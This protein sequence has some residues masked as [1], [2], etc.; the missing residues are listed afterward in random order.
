MS[1]IPRRLIVPKNITDAL[2][3]VDFPGSKENIVDLDMVQ[4]IRIAGK[5]VSFSL[6][7]QRS[8]DPQ[9]EVVKEACIA[10]IAKY[11]GD[12]VE[13]QGNISVKA[14]HQMERPLLAGVRNIVAVASGKGGVGKSTVSVNLAVALANTGAKVGLI[15]ADIFGPSL[16]KM[17]GVEDVRPAGIKI[18]GRDMIEP[19]EKFGVKMLSIGFFVAAENALIWRGPMASNALKQLIA[20][21]NWGDLDYLL[22]DLPPGTSDIHLSLVQTIPVTGAVIV[23][24]PQ[25]VALADVVKGVSM[26]QSK[27]IDVPVLGLI[28]NMAWFTPE[29]LPNNKYYIFGKEGGKKLADQMG[30]VLMGQIP[31]V[32][33]IREGG[34]SGN[35]SAADPASPVGQAFAEIAESLITQLKIR[36]RDIDPT[37][38]VKVSRK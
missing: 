37:K 38:K 28:E 32:Q 12:D 8:D 23:T 31:I 5:K 33:S 11:V 10:A 2:R 13:V 26:F 29:E 4:E 6:V 19:V 17:F 25:D 1:D 27:S 21:G 24:T 14:I 16:P 7:F 36:N 34:D 3:N 30:L 22:I 18:G 9:I 15:D 20:D 35:P